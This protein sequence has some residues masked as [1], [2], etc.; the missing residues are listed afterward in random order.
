M[1]IRVIAAVASILLVAGTELG[2]QSQLPPTLARAT[3]DTL[4]RLVDSARAVGLPT[5]PLIAKAQE[6]VL[7][8]VSD[9]RI[10]LAVRALV[11]RQA[12]ARALLPVTVAP[13][14][15]AAAVSALQAGV[16]PPTVRRLAQ[17][18]ASDA[19][20][21]SALVVLADLIAS[22]VPPGPAAAS[23]EQLLVRRAPEAELENLRATVAR[24]IAA[25]QVPEAALE[26]RTQAIVRTLDARPRTPPLPP[27]SSVPPRP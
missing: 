9:E 6:G 17:S 8:R 16:A 3:R 22:S 10:I 4:E 21:A 2:A 18:G 7:K 23:V 27:S 14:T 11:R 5:E 26:S 19:D 15:L 20:L 12:D 25:G 1:S 24:D 13:A